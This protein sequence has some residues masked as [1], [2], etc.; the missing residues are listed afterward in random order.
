MISIRCLIRLKI[1]DLITMNLVNSSIMKCLLVCLFVVHKGVAEDSNVD[2]VVETAGQYDLPW[3]I[4]FLPDNRILL[5]EM[6]GSLKLLDSDGSLLGEVTGVPEVAFGGQGGLGDVVLH[7]DFEKNR[8]VYLSYAEEGPNKTFGAAVARGNLELTETGGQLKDL[9]V[10][11]RQVPK[12]KG[13]GHYGHRIV[14]GPDNY[15]WISS[16]ERQ[17][18][19]PAQDMESNLGKI[20]RLYTSGV[21][22]EDNPFG[23]ANPVTSE[24][25]SLG[26]R[27]PLGLSFDTSGRLW[28]VEMGPKGGDELNLVR[29]GSNYGYPVVSNGDHYSGEEI[30]D[31]ETRHEY[32]PPAITWDKVISPSSMLVYDGG[33]FPKWKGNAFIGGLSSKAIVRVSF[34]GDNAREV[35]RFNMGF[36]VRE[37]EQG[38]AG[39]VWV[40]EDGRRGS[41]KLFKL[42]RRE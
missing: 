3:A 23:S 7:P 24:I 9:E 25:W 5:S 41:G 34:D 27:N 38:P 31:H 28:T 33:E 40:L 37:V 39:G 2:F 8:D 22:V 14:F 6:K 1:Q 13:R 20:V 36:R 15:L 18:F 35:E 4:E 10:I 30:P 26:H 29:R 21:S 16:G 12:V 32:S 42:T 17:K 11:W 19:D